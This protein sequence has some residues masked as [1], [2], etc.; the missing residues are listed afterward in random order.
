M[1]I[2][3]ALDSFKGCLSAAAACQAVAE[4]LQAVDPTIRV[5]I[6]PMADGG[7]GTATTLL[8]ARPSGVWIPCT[9]TGP[10]PQQRVNAGFAWFADDRTAVV[11]MAAASGLTLVP[12]HERDPMATTTFGTGELLA[13][14]AAKGARHIV[15]TIGGSATVDGGIGAAAALGWRF[16]DAAGAAVPP[17]G[18]HL[19]AIAKIVPPS[20]RCLPRMTVLCDVT[21]R[22]CGLR[23]AA[24]VFGPQKG[25][26]PAQVTQLDAGLRHLAD[27][28][29]CDLG[30]DVLALSGGGA[31]GGL[32]AGAVAFL[33]ATLAPGIA[34]V[35]EAAGLR[36]A[37]QDAT[38]C[39]TGEGCFDDSSLDGKVVSGV[40][41]AAREAGVPVVVF[42][43]EVRLA[44]EVYGAYGIRGAYALRRPDMTVAESL[45][46][47]PELLQAC[48]SQWLRRRV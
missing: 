27:Q 38:W 33:E 24:A 9:V 35:I 32:G 45:H 44:P 36:T 48:A 25:A 42:A 21:H 6:K 29:A 23:G 15:L 11:E 20:G 18:G 37:L 19:H 43:G 10:L 39:I 3:V 4:G 13:A 31:A 34:T 17:D 16:L 2:V 30:R 28:I 5:R 1:T 22:L 8:A 41:H 7:E 12:E 46:R 47:A 40:A 14:A 26:T